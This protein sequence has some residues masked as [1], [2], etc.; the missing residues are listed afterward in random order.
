[1]LNPA[2]EIWRAILRV[3]GDGAIGGPYED[4]GMVLK[5]DRDSDAWEELQGTDSFFPYRVGV[6]GEPFTAAP[7]SIMPITYGGWP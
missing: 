2:G 7:R 3:A 4:V 5:P 1:M 6:S